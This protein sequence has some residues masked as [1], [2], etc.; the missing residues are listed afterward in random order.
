MLY[1]NLKAVYHK[2]TLKLQKPLK[3]P[4]GATV[5]VSVQT[6]ARDN[7]EN[8]MRFAGAWH[9]MAEDAF[10]DY[11]AEVSQRRESAFSRRRGRETGNG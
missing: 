8:V 9:D 3:I 2:G 11:L 7:A 10:N 5:Q 6:A 1:P 4:E